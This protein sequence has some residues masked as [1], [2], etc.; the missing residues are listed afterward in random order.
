MVVMRSAAR[1]A[2][3]FVLAARTP[4]EALGPLVLFLLPPAALGFASG[5]WFGRWGALATLLPAP[6]VYVGY[7]LA[8]P[9]PLEQYVVTWLVMAAPIAA[10]W[11][12]GWGVRAR[13]AQQDRDR[14]RPV[15]VPP[16]EESRPTA[17][18]GRRV[19]PRPSWPS[20]RRSSHRRKHPPPTS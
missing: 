2:I 5:P 10:G 7:Q 1:S 8:E 13:R 18:A 15:E 17:A 12:M 11:F 6:V 9:P 20:T 19:G 14:P 3:A 4:G 16:V